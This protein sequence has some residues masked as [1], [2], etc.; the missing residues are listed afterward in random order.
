MRWTVTL[1]AEVEPGQS[2]EHDIAS[3]D[4][5]ERITPA[6]L[7]LSIAEGK[8]VLAA[9]QAQ[10]VVDQVKR[11]GEVARHCLWCGRVAVLQGPLPV[12]LSVGLR[13][14]ADAGAAISGV[15]MP[16][17]RAEDGAGVVHAPI[18]HRAGTAVPH[19]EAGRADAVRQSGRFSRARC[20]RSR[21]GSTRAPSATARCASG[22]DCC[23]PEPHPLASRRRPVSTWSSASTARMC[24]IGTR[25]RPARSR[26][27]WGRSVSAGDAATRFAFVRRGSTAGAATITQALREHGVHPDTRVTVLSDGDAGL[28]RDAARGRAG[29]RPGARLVSH[30]DALAARASTRHRR[31]PSGADRRGAHLAARSDRAGE[32]GPLEW[33]AREDVRPSLGTARLDLERA[34]GSRRGWSTC[35]PTSVS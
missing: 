20:C 25:G 14:R 12:D 32:M 8:A 34:G 33:P 23:A 4:R 10:L 2:I 7:G 1:V 29:G 11:H 9:I 21:R 5:D 16:D 17:R 28:A 6:T 15:P 18:A 31:D 27:W 22:N 35:A 3:V 13:Q 26:S 30:R 19:R 24:A